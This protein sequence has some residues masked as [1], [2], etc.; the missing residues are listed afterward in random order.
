MF[1]AVSSKETKKNHMFPKFNYSVANEVFFAAF[2]TC[3][4][5]PRN[6][7]GISQTFEIFPRKLPFHLNFLPESA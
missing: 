7:R 4:H 2:P 3:R 5:W 6:Q 1:K